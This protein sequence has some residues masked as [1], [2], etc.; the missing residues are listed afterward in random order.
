MNLE[1]NVNEYLLAWYL[2]Y[3]ASLS[4]EI[5]KFRKNLWSKYKL[6]YNFCYKDKGEIIKYGKDFIP[7]NDVLYNEIFNSELYLSLKKETNRHKMYLTKIFNNDLKKVKKNLISILKMELK[8]TYNIYVIH[9]RMEVIE[10]YN[11]S[12]NCSILWGSEKDK[13]DA[14]KILMLT[15][16]KSSININN[17]YKEITDSIIELAVINEMGKCLGN[18]DS[19]YEGNQ[20]L[21]MIKRQI[22]PFWLMYL[23][24]DNKETI[25]N[26]MIDDKIGFDIENYPIDK[27]MKKMDLEDFINFCIKNNKHILKLNNVLSIEKNEEIEVI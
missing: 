2:L 3:G 10:Y 24:Y 9:P 20:T 16:V 18:N 12:N 6:E 26:R 15:I 25:L 23:G 17:D 19:Y 8:K 14:L 11:I 5:D 13:Y 4:K 7:D 21:K 22:Y 1:I 27:N